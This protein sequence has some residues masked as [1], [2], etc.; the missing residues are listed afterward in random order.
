MKEHYIVT[1]TEANDVS[2]SFNLRGTMKNSLQKHILVIIMLVIILI[3]IIAFIVSMDYL[4][5]KEEEPMYTFNEALER[6]I[7]NGTEDLKFN[8]GYL[9]PASDDDIKQAMQ[10]D[11]QNTYQFVELNNKSK[12]PVETLNELLK[13]AG[14]LKGTGEYFLK[15]EEEYD[16]NALYLIA[17]AKVETGN[18]KSKL[19]KGIKVDDKTYYNFYGIGAFDVAAIKEGS[20]YAKKAK[21]DSK[22]RAI[23][24]GAKFIRHE[25]FDNDQNTLYDMRWNPNN[26]GTHLYA[27]DIKWPESISDILETHYKVA[28]IKPDFIDSKIYKEEE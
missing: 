4:L 10:P 6:Q 27:T 23:I 19:A 18:G 14:V 2:L 22:E 1:K 7:S 20:S 25:Y 17:H 15:A 5:E 26:P 12:V 24:G 28:E 21:W 8:D 9:V 16:V 11:L 3:F 13:D